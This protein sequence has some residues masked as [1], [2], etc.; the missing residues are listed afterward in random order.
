M[1]ST[2][3]IQFLLFTPQGSTEKVPFIGGQ[4]LDDPPAAA[5]PTAGRGR[6]SRP[7]QILHHA[8]MRLITADDHHEADRNLSLAYLH[9]QS[10]IIC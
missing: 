2:V 10:R 9:Q 8:L 3:E 4:I 5:H 1:F 6:P 7:A